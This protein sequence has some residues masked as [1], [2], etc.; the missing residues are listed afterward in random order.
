MFKKYI[1]TKVVFVKFFSF[2]LGL[3]SAVDMAQTMS[4]NVNFCVCHISCKF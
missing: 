2:H 3:L 1:K 4:I